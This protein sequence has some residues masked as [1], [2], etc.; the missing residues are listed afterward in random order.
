M[1]RNNKIRRLIQKI[2][3]FLAVILAFPQTALA[4]G[5]G[6][7]TVSVKAEEDVYFTAYEML[8]F[9]PDEEYPY[10]GLTLTANCEGI[11]NPGYQWMLDG[12]EITGANS[13]AYTTTEDDFGKILSVKVIDSNNSSVTKT[14]SAGKVKACPIIYATCNFGASNEIIINCTV[15]RDDYESIK[16][17]PT[18]NIM[19]LYAVCDND[20]DID[21]LDWK[22]ISTINIDTSLT[23]TWSEFPNNIFGEG[24]YIRPVYSGDDNYVKTGTDPIF[25]AINDDNRPFISGVDDYEIY[26]NEVT[27]YVIDTNLSS[28]TIKEDNDEQATNLTI[29]NNTINNIS[30]KTATQTVTE[31]GTYT[32][33]A[34]DSAGNTSTGS[35]IIAQEDVVI[36][37]K[38]DTNITY[39]PSAAFDVSGLFTIPANAG[40]ATYR[41]VPDEAEGAG[42]GTLGEDG[43]TLTI[44]KAG[45]ITIEVRTA[46]STYAAPSEKTAVLTVN[47]ATL[48]NTMLSLN[49]SAFDYI[50]GTTHTPALT[51]KDGNSVLALDTDYEIVTAESTTSADAVG[52]YT[53]KVNGKGNYTGSAS[54][55]WKIEKTDNTA[56][57]ITGVENDT[58]YNGEVTVSIN[59]KNL[60]SVT[61]REDNDEQATS[62]TISDTT[63]DNNPTKTA[64][65]TVTELGTYTVTATDSAGNTS[66]CSFTI[67]QGEVIITAKT[68]EADTT[69][70][71]APSATFD[72]SGL[73]TIPANA[74]TATYS[75]VPDEAE[76]A[77]AGILGEDGKT[78][79]ITK[80]G[81]ITIEVRTAGSTYAAPSEKIN[82][83]TVAK[84]KGDLNV[85]IKDVVYGEDI[86]LS[87][88]STTYTGKYTVEYTGR[89]TTAYTATSKAPTEAGT[90]TVTVTYSGNNLYD[91]AVKSVD[92]EITPATLTVTANN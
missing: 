62:L 75:V 73:F 60:S 68:D 88:N 82:I 33:T 80:A 74:G 43:K 41:V 6:L 11:A 87:V 69:I 67:A 63:I 30:I 17:N 48:N 21:S 64:T 76:G 49:R 83:L 71:Y 36:T 77:G 56:P 20:N 55:T 86:D 28:V 72:V 38:T 18:G 12:E 16:V 58:T 31:L 84:A 45:T 4:Q 89:G 2:A 51:V 9:N 57:V 91:K 22:E 32:V 39:A 35:F 54:I 37:A 85:G 92:F 13:Q 44:T 42:A 29:S 19:L 65:Q 10:I 53:I 1:E 24:I 47:K 26:N 14:A 66:T 90:Y 46:G 25:L 78:L 15:E 23:Y 79:T 3:V 40:T 50:V 34:T 61:I 70:T 52:T 59:D 7:G 8:P 5:I 27:V 81:T